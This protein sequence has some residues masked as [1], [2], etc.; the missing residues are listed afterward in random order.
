ML[1]KIDSF[2]GEYRFLSNFFLS[3]ITYGEIN[4]PTVEHAYQA[5]KTSD[6]SEVSKIIN[7]K[8]PGEA[9]RLGRKVTMRPEFEQNK[10]QIMAQ[11]IR[12]KFPK[13]SRLAGMLLNTYPA[14]LIEGN[15]WNDTFWGVCRGRGENMLGKIL[16]EWREILSEYSK[17][18]T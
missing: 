5:S 16:M 9:K 17:K 4:Y 10:L 14:T 8:T 11:L 3:P 18:A 12:L 7:C 13:D 15:N 2:S 6:L 1:D